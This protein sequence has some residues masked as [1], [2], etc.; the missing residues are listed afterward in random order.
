VT[1]PREVLIVSASPILSAALHTFLERN[2]IPARCGVAEAETRSDCRAAV[3]RL[4]YDEPDA[5]RSSVILLTTGNWE[6]TA[7]GVEVARASYADRPWLL[8]MDARLAGAFLHLLACRPCGLVPP[9][10][11][12]EILPDT[13]YALASG[14]TLPLSF[15]LTARFAHGVRL[16]LDGRPIR[17]PT[18]S[19]LQCGC[20]A[21]L[22]LSNSQIAGLLC[23]GEATVKT[24]LH[25]LLQKLELH[26]RGQLGRLVQQ[27]LAPL[28]QTKAPR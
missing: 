5:P 10:A 3:P 7:W 1:S 16:A 22:G 2:G 26:S 12:P 13:L 18:Q 4:P 14:H 24:H 27:A 9:S 8:L 19:E 15:E 28:P 25:H 17:L 23:L 21:S 20:A 11:S 6:E